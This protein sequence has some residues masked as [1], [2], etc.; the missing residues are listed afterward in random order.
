M[1]FKEYYSAREQLV[2]ILKDDFLGPVSEDEVLTEPPVVYYISGKLYPKNILKI[3]DNGDV[4]TEEDIFDDETELLSN[5]MYQSA[6]G[7]TFSISAE[8]K[9]FDIVCNAAYYDYS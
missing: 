9:S 1:D 8:T 5:Q 7:I 4:I 6:M 3:D 2:K